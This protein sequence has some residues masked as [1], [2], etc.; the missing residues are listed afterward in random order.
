M[1]SISN[2]RTPAGTSIGFGDTHALK[3]T[4]TIDTTEVAHLNR[5]EA[6]Q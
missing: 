4:T 2:T 1:D 5:N 6:S 3:Q